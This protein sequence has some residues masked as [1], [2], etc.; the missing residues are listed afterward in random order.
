MGLT[1]LPQLAESIT[2]SIAFNA[3]VIRSPASASFCTFDLRQP[4]CANPQAL[5]AIGNST[6]VIAADP[7]TDTESEHGFLVMLRALL[8]LDGERPLGTKL[9]CVLV[10]HK[11]TQCYCIA[12]YA[13]PSGNAKP[14][15]RHAEERDRCSFR[16]ALEDAG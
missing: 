5:H 4:R 8:G 15:I 1:D 14:V 6:V 13:A 9:E 10:A 16:R 11:P 3:S 7:V 12:G 2:R